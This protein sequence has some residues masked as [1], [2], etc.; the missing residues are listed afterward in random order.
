M[1]VVERDSVVVRK[2]ATVRVDFTLD[3]T[4]TDGQRDVTPNSWALPAPPPCLQP[5]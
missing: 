3:R 5:G 2:G 1:P 4:W